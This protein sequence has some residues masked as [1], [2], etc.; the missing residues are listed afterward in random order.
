MSWLEDLPSGT[1]AKA[2]SALE[3][4]GSNFD[5]ARPRSSRAVSYEP[6][7]RLGYTVKPSIFTP[8]TTEF[9]II[10]FEG[11]KLRTGTDKTKRLLDGVRPRSLP[12]GSYEPPCRPR[13]TVKRS[14]FTPSTT[15]IWYHCVRT[16]F[17]HVEKNIPFRSM[18]T[19]SRYQHLNLL[20]E[21]VAAILFY[22]DW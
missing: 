14:I 7:R 11:S 22:V 6:P 10:V 2:H 20:S 17:V 16:T 5:G 8:T 3:R 13:Y 15:Q 12:A 19:N 1:L 9:G 4:S 21:K 18:P